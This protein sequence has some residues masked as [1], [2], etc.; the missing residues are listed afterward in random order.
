MKLKYFIAHDFGTSGAKSILIDEVGTILA[1][2]IFN[3][4]MQTPHPGWVEQ[5]PEDYWQA[6]I[7]STQ[8]LM[9]EAKVEASDIKGIVF[10]TQAMG[11]IP[12]DVQGNVLHPNISW[13]D[14]RAEEEAVLLMRKFGGKKIFK[15]IVG[16]EIT[17][18]DVIPK[19]I[20][21][22]L[23]RPEIYQKTHHF[24]D[25]NGYLKFKCTGKMVAEWSGACSYAFNLNKKD[26]ER[27]FFRI[28]GVDLKKLPPLV[29]STDNIG[30]LTETAAAAFGLLAG[31]PVY[32]G[33]DDTQSAAI[34]SGAIGEGQGHIYLGTA[35]QLTFTTSKAPKFKNGAVA[36]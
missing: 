20:W 2:T 34:G 11:V 32:G 18:K 17:G 4:S 14:G 8:K 25:V 21:L 12:V 7:Q 30:G 19:L 22:K 3:Y 33:C 24:L 29:K 35:A 6:A 28:A 1:H 15:A 36:L 26:W 10:T 31:T 9:L 13:V 16:I 27:I 5:L 23:N